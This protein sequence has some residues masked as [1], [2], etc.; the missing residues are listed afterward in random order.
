MLLFS[1]VKVINGGENISDGLSWV[2]L[3]FLVSG[4]VS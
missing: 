1:V 4:G 2:S 3:E